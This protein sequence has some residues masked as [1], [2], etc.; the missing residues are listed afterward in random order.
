MHYG[1]VVRVKFKDG[2][3]C[4]LAWQR[5]ATSRAEALKHVKAGFA[6]NNA[7]VPGTSKDV[8]G[9]L[10]DI[11]EAGECPEGYENSIKLYEAACVKA[12]KLNKKATP[13]IPSSELAQG[14]GQLLV[15]K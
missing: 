7:F 2:S 11:L 14:S 6:E 12:E 8:W 1:F 9:E 4:H 5:L 13:P 15:V 3:V 10:V